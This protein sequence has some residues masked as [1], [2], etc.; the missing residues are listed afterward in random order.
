M[1]KKKKAPESHN[2]LVRF[3]LDQ[4]ADGVLLE[5]TGLSASSLLAVTDTWETTTLALE[6]DPI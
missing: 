3:L 1:I 4:I 5:K 2:S 6:P